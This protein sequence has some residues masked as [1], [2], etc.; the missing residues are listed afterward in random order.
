MTT[1]AHGVSGNFNIRTNWNG[2][3]VPGSGQD[4]DL[5]PTGTYTVTVNIADAVN[6]V[7]GVQTSANAT[8]DLTEGTF[9]ALDGTDTGANDGTILIGNNTVFEIGGA[10]GAGPIPVNDFGTIKLDSTGS[11]TILYLNGS[12]SDQEIDLTGG[13]KL[14]L[15][16]NANN[17]IE[18]A[19]GTILN[20]ENDTISGAGTINIA[21][22]DNDNSGVINADDSDPLTI[23]VGVL[24]NAGTVKATSTGGLIIQDETVDNVGGTVEATTSG[25]VID[26]VGSSISGGTL[27]TVAGS[28]I[29]IRSFGD[30]TI[31]PAT[32][33]NAGNIILQD[34]A[35][36]TLGAANP[37]NNTGTIALHAALGQTI[38]ALEGSVVLTG[39][40]KVTLTDNPGNIIE[41]NGSPAALI[42]TNN[43]ISGAGTIGDINTMLYNQGTI[44]G[45]GKNPLIIAA[46]SVANPGTIETSGAG[47]LEIEHAVSNTNGTVATTASGAHIDLDNGSISYGTVKTVAGSTIDTVA[48]TSGEVIDATFNNAGRLLLNNQSSFSLGSNVDNTGSIAVENYGSGHTQLEIV[49]DVSLTGTGKV[50]LSG[51]NPWII[52]DGSAAAL[53]NDGNTISGDGLI[54]DSKLTLVN[55][56]RGVIDANNPTL[57]LVISTGTNAVSNAGTMEATAGGLLLLLSPIINTGKII[58]DNATVSLLDAPTGSGSLV[59]EGSGN[60]ALTAAGTTQGVTFA[61]GATGKLTLGATATTTPTSVY[62]GKISGFG[63]GDAIDLAGLAYVAG[64][65]LISTGPT[66]T[67]GPGGGSTTFTVANGTDAV[68]LTF[69]G[70]LTSHTFVLGEDTGGDVLITDPIS[71]PAAGGHTLANVALLGSYIASAFPSAQGGFTATTTETA[72]SQ[73]VLAH[74]HIGWGAG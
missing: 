24:T 71:R 1:W 36:L 37:I 21:A 64:T 3:A 40:G 61:S 43:T 4:A 12:V 42:N 17:L 41:S 30:T 39:K 8:L 18:D 44:D 62:D 53:I 13:G 26:F 50:T 63:T 70:N 25:S 6:T 2:G 57:A 28:S 68:Q 58:A 69:A 59:I 74:P 31:N 48:G 7:L 51:L 19:P 34:N 9:I 15:S 72:E 49:A 38:L 27:S 54:G 73:A 56:S 11:T 66:F 60:M 35:K 5:S 46:D 65:T 33:T 45:T 29:V 22:L 67:P 20:N 55:D 52:S 10:S 23:R 32:L 14:T 16:N 47:G